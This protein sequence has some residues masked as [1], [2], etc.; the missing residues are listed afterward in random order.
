MDANATSRP[1]IGNRLCRVATS[2]ADQVFMRA[3]ICGT[4]LCQSWL[5]AT[6]RS[7]PHTLCTREVC[8]ISSPHRRDGTWFVGSRI[9]T[10]APASPPYLE[11]GLPY[12]HH[13]FISAMATCCAAAGLLLISPGFGEQFANIHNSIGQFTGMKGGCARLDR[14]SLPPAM[15]FAEDMRIVGQQGFE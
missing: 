3:A 2:I 14:A 6:A 5:P 15:I 7:R 9:P 12:G 8:D 13:Q 10:E 11:S 4:R 1:L